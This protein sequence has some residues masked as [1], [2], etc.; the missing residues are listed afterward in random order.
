MPT[1]AQHPWP[2]S[3]SLSTVLS[4]EEKTPSGSS[5][6]ALPGPACSAVCVR[7]EVV[8]SRQAVGQSSAAGTA[9]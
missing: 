5:S 3:G 6:A 8:D 9:L 4:Q 2:Q 7:G 1:A